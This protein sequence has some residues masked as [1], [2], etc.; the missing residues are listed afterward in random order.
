MK[1]HF[2]I[3]WSLF[4]INEHFFHKDVAHFSRYCPILHS[5]KKTTIYKTRLLLPF[6]QNSTI[7]AMLHYCAAW[8]SF[9]T[10][11]CKWGC[12]VP[13]DGKTDNVWLPFA[14]KQTC[15]V[16][17]G[18]CQR[19]NYQQLRDSALQWVFIQCLTSGTL[20]EM[21]TGQFLSLDIG[22]P[23]KKAASQ[24]TKLAIYGLLKN[25]RKSSWDK[26]YSVWKSMQN[27]H[28]QE[29]FSL[30]CCLNQATLLSF[31]VPNNWECPPLSG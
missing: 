21:D 15:E 26:L 30:P 1:R 24:P 23:K 16:W 12:R 6:V 29:S 2:K 13:H 19:L 11:G 18:I 27:P 20:P 4:L 28:N 25:Q 7:A 8:T 14:S 10:Q 9:E 31:S 22:Y 5:S 17:L 3:L